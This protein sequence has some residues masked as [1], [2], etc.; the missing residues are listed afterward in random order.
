[1]LQGCER[2]RRGEDCQGGVC[3]IAIYSMAMMTTLHCCRR[4]LEQRM[5]KQGTKIIPRLQLQIMTTRCK[6]GH[7][8]SMNAGMQGIVVCFSFLFSLFSFLVSVPEYHAETG[9]NSNK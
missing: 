8:I 9:R 4:W 1:L 7:V 5:M 6:C 2:C 3:A